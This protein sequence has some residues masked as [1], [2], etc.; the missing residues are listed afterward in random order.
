MDTFVHYAKPIIHALTLLWRQGTAEWAHQEIVLNEDGKYYALVQICVSSSH[1]EKKIDPVVVKASK[2]LQK[3]MKRS[4]EKEDFLTIFFGPASDQIEVR[5][6]E[7]R[8]RSGNPHTSKNV[9]I[10]SK[11][12][13]MASTIQLIPVGLEIMTHTFII[14]EFAESRNFQKSSVY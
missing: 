14:F 11:P 10:Y 1:R 7:I 9:I 6:M 2:K 8:L 5:N 4:L 12:M 3:V 13:L